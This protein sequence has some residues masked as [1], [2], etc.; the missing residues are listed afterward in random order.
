MDQEK[1]Y[2]QAI[3]L[4]PDDFPDD[5]AK[6]KVKVHVAE[7]EGVDAATSAEEDTSP[8]RAPTLPP[9]NVKVPGT[10]TRP[11]TRSRAIREPPVL[12]RSFRIRAND[13]KFN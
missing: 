7:V 1:K 8:V 9:K 13:V 3:M 10:L 6:R 11:F 5:N 2:P 4:T 12:R